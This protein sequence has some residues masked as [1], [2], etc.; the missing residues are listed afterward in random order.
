MD[1]A[2]SQIPQQ[3]IAILQNVK[4]LLNRLDEQC[5]KTKEQLLKERE[6]TGNLQAQIDAHAYRRIHALPMAVQR[7]FLDF[8]FAKTFYP[9][10]CFKFYHFFCSPKQLLLFS[11]YVIRAIT[12]LK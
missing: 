6:R 9:F 5:V 1:N 10:Q 11:H 7:G 4:A 3:Q 8:Y 2:L 12:S